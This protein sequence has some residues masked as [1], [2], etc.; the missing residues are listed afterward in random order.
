VRE[1]S[2]L[3][4]DDM[5]ATFLAGEL[6][7]ERFAPRL[8]AALAQLGVPEAEV[9][10][11]DTADPAANRRRRA[12]MRAYRRY[13]LPDSLFDGFPYGDVSWARV[14]LTPA[15]LLAARYIGGYDYWVAL[16][17]GTRL[18]PDAARRIRAGEVDGATRQGFLRLAAA[19]AG[20][21]VFDPLILVT[22]GVGAPLVVLEGHAR[23][24]AYALRPERIPDPVVAVL[25]TSPRMAEWGAY[26]P[27]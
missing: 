10:R 22:E 14:A 8:R 23:L 16:S 2:P 18:A 11:P 21:A 25:G 15:E 3:T 26:L 20:G 7:S 12:V 6:R 24:T 1:L 17:A 13:G 5:L 9:A 19:L 4:E 27:P